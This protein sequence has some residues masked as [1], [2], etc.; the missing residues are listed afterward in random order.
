MGTGVAGGD[1][2]GGTGTG[3]DTTSASTAATT[4]TGGAAGSEDDGG[5]GCRMTGD[6]SPRNASYASL[7]TIATAALGVRR[8]RS[9]S[10]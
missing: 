3:G 2:T 4:G 10:R 6:E 9:R 7:F 8:R 1:G 5:C